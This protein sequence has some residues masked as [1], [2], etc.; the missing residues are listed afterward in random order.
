M[1]AFFQSVKSDLE[2]LKEAERMHFSFQLFI[3]VFILSTTTAQITD[4]DVPTSTDYLLYSYSAYCN[5]ADLQTWT[6]HWCNTSS[7]VRVIYVFSNDTTNTYGY[8]GYNDKEILFSFRGTQINS[9]SNIITDLESQ[10]L[11][12]YPNGK[13]QVAAGFFDAYQG[14]RN[15]VRKA[16]KELTTK[17]PKLPVSVTGHSLGAALSS[18]AGLDFAEQYG[19]KI[20]QWS[21]GSPRIGDETFTKYFHSKMQTVWRTV[22]QADIVPHYPFRWEGFYHTATEVWFPTDY[23]HF[24]LCDGSG[25]D[26]TCSDSLGM[27]DWSVLD[28]LEYFGYFELAGKL[29]GC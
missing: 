1:K 9:L 17:F 8:A 2:K 25:E 24:K 26:P 6:C 18:M 29:Y 15:S 12:D 11:V 28:H 23:T 16:Y 13:G 27:F 4:Y 21:Y 22:N 10:F 3:I 7:A 19:A 14:I 20:S 5:A